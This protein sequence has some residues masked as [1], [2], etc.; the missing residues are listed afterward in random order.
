MNATMIPLNLPSDFY[1]VIRDLLGYGAGLLPH[2]WRNEIAPQQKIDRVYD[3]DGNSAHDIQNV[4]SA[5]FG[6][7]SALPPAPDLNESVADYVLRT[8]LWLESQR[9]GLDQAAQTLRALLNGS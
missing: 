1:A 9:I 6:Y 4:L 8:A 7:N 2:E 5:A 3:F